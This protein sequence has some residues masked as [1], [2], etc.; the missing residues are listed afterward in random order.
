LNFELFADAY[1]SE[2]AGATITF[3]D[4]T[5]VDGTVSLYFLRS[6]GH[7][8]GDLR[9]W[10]NDDEDKAALLSGFWGFVSVGARALIAKDL[11]AGVYSVTCRSVQ[12]ELHDGNPGGN[13][14]QII[15]VMAT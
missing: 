14:T 8:M 7:D 11:K 9:C 12:G 2:Q 5:V 1:R 10:V 13:R 4:I 3:P 15:A 6:W